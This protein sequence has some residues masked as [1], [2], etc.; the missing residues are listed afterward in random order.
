MRDNLRM[1]VASAQDRNRKAKRI[2]MKDLEDGDESTGQ[3]RL[4]FGNK[5]DA[6]DE[7]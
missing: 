2:K 4:T 5:R 7:D 1:L 6:R 3:M